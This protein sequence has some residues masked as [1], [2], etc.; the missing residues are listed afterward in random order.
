MITVIVAVVAVLAVAFAALA[1]TNNN[2]DNP[3]V[4]VIY[5]GNGGTFDGHKTVE[6]TDPK[7]SINFFVNGDKQFIN[8]NTARDGS[9]TSY[10][11]GDAVP[12]GVPTLYAQW[13]DTTGI[14]HVNKYL[15]SGP[16]GHF[17]VTLNGGALGMFTMNEVYSQGNIITLKPA[18][19][20]QNL[21]YDSASNRFTYDYNSTSYALSVN[22]TGATDDIY[23]VFEGNAEVGFKATSDVSIS[24]TI[25]IVSAP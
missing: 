18:E 6:S 5:D 13:K 3:D 21:V 11:P 12:A 4:T 9:G 16:T 8:W 7:V 22:V 23:D 17:T 2:D 10:K 20:I 25:S 19:G 14:Y 24:I 1:L 15:E